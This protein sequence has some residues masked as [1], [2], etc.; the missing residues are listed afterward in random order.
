MRQCTS[1]SRGRSA[2]GDHISAADALP[3]SGPI[4][5]AEGGP[6]RKRLGPFHVSS[7]IVAGRLPCLTVVPALV[8][9][10]VTPPP[11]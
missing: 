6:E 9:F 11:E 10:N 1:P 7:H 2:D 5:E 8:I 4:S 3:V